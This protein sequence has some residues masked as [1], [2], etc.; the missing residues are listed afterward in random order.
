MLGLAMKRQE[1]VRLQIGKWGNSLAIRLPSTLAQQAALKEGDYL[2]ADV[3]AEGEVVL[4][5]AHNFDPDAFLA[6]LDKLH[7]ALPQT[8]P[9]ID[10]LREE[11]RY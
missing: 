5:P 4:A 1:T 2:E 9:V 7:H 10:T 6:V 8:E 3:T 11:A